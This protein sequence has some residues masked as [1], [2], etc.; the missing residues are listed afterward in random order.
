MSEPKEY[1]IGDTATAEEL[2]LTEYGKTLN[3]IVRLKPSLWSIELI[4]ARA[5]EGKD[6]AE[7]WVRVGRIKDLWRREY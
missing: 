7:G 1:D 4:M 6:V 2:G 5:D 3:F